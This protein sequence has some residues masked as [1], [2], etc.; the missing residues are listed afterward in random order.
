MKKRKEKHTNDN[1]LR[2][3]ILKQGNLEMHLD[4]KSQITVKYRSLENCFFPLLL[5]IVENNLFTKCP[6]VTTD[7]V[8][9]YGATPRGT[10]C[11]MILPNYF[12]LDME[13]GKFY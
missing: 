6:L 5:S 3:Q 10:L 8:I 7:C 4:K 1:R 9:K 11:K 12:L 2:E 13:I